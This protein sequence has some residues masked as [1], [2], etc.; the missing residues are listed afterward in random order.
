MMKRVTLGA[1]VS[2]CL[3]ELGRCEMPALEA[4]LDI[5]VRFLSTSTA[6]DASIAHLNALQEEAGQD[7]WNRDTVYAVLWGL[8]VLFQDCIKS[9]IT[10]ER[11]KTLIEASLDAEK[12]SRVAAF[13]TAKQHLLIQFRG[14]DTVRALPSYAD[15]EWRVDVELSRRSLRRM[16]APSFMVRLGLADGSSR[17]QESRHLQSDFANLRNVER[18]LGRALQEFK[19]THSQRFVRYL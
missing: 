16:A 2:D 6:S 7:A 3:S 11:L 10:E 17:R 1:R 15:M 19:G 12:R 14:G 18:E 8:N 13:Y 4:V 9:G 5:F